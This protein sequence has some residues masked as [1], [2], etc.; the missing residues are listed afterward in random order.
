MPGPVL[1]TGEVIQVALGGLPAL[2]DAELLA[3]LRKRAPKT[4][5][6]PG[7]DPLAEAMGLTT[8]ARGLGGWPM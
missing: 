3:R 4:S 6:P 5:P 2:K 7:R 1:G 8:N